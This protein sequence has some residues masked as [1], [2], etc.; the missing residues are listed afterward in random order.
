MI[1]LLLF[2]KLVLCLGVI[3]SELKCLENDVVCFEYN[4]DK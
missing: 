4:V 1:G 3:S 2:R